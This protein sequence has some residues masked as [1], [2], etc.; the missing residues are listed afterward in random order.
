MVLSYYSMT[1]QNINE[2]ASRNGFKN[3]KLG[4]SKKGLQTRGVTLLKPEYLKNKPKVFQLIS[5]EQLFEHPVD[6][7]WIQ[8]DA[9]D[10]L[11]GITLS[12]DV[13]KY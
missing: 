4:T 8:F 11:S 6:V 9:N 12:L 5:I 3:Y 13:G 10:K 1:S 7:V 2:L